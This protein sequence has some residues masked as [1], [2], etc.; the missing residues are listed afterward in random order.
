MAKV[1]YN[2]RKAFILAVKSSHMKK[3][4]FNVL[5]FVALNVLFFAIYLNF[6]HKDTN[7]LPAVSASTN[8]AAKNLGS[9]QLKNTMV[10]NTPVKKAMADEN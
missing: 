7:V 8:V 2:Y 3:R 9:E 6:I 4:L 10:I 1:F 5:N